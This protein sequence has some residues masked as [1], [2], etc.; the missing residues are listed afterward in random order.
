MDS[1][2]KDL[3]ASLESEKSRVQELQDR[4]KER[5]SLIHEL[6]IEVE[7]RKYHSEIIEKQDLE[8]KEKSAVII[9][10]GIDDSDKILKV[11]RALNSNPF[12]IPKEFLTEILLFVLT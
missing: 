7:K 8:S 5:D 3:K 2:L 9:I 4:L 6:N 10:C 11:M 1:S 12:T